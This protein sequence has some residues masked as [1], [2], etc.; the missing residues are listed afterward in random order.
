MMVMIMTVVIAIMVIMVMMMVMMMV[1]MVV[2]M[3]VMVVVI[4]DDNDDGGDDDDG[5]DGDDDNDDDDGG[6]DGDDDDDD[7]DDDDGD[8]ND[9]DDD[10]GDGN[11]GDGN[12]DNND[13]NRLGIIPKWKYN[14]N[15][16]L[17]IS[18]QFYDSIR[19][20]ILPY[21][22]TLFHFFIK[23]LFVFL[24][25]YFMF[26]VINILQTTDF[27]GTVKVVSTMSVSAVP[28]IF[29]VMAAKISE[30]EEK[31]QNEVQKIKVKKLVS[32]LTEGTDQ[33]HQIYM[34]MSDDEI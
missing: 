3:V 5:D 6:D 14:R 4:Y 20:K 34:K 31:A 22:L 29:N 8:G 13:S 24:F 7:G 28:Y 32:E 17:I 27:S 15:N 10:D 21:N 33:V 18:K 9:G 1:V 2:I 30:E 11:D 16:Q 23:V 25:A 26:T 19:E 12:D